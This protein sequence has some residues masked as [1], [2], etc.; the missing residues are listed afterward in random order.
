[1]RIALL[2]DD[3]PQA[4]LIAHWLAE[5]GMACVQFHT[6]AAFRQ[7]IASQSVDLIL[8]DW[9]LP[10]DDGVEVLTWLRNTLGSQVPVMFTTTRAE[11]SALVHAL[12]HGAD[13]YLIKPLRRSEMIARIHALLRRGDKAKASSVVT[14]GSIVI[15]SGRHT[16]TVNGVPVDLTDRELEL[17]LYLLRNHGRLLTRRE[18]LENVWNTNPQVVT[19]TV[20][21]HISRLRI[22]LGLTAENGFELTTVYHKGYRL[23]YQPIAAPSANA[24]DVARPAGVEAIR[25][26][27]LHHLL[28]AEDNPDLRLILEAA[29][30]FGGLKAIICESGVEALAQLADHT[31]DLILLDVMMPG[32]DG[33]ETLQALRKLP[34]TQNTPVIFVTA[35]AQPSEIQDYLALGAIAVIPKP[36]DPAMLANRIKEIWREHGGLA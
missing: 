28:C 9:I 3:P 5:A 32:L 33:P 4:S 22:K 2:E 26:K 25:G 35:R 7:G 17:A 19:R 21:T 34:Q 30:G 20:D 16:A 27:S 18:L 12:D 10:D 36:F 29:L 1:M 8:I 14:L 6:G 13:D 23:E 24:T 11:E 31:P 15:D